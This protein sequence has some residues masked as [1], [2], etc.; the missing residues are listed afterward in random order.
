MTIKKKL[1]IAIPIYN[2]EIRLKEF[3]EDLIFLN[4][5]HIV[6]IIISDDASDD[7]SNQICEKFVK[8][9]DFIKLYTHKENFGMPV[10]NFQFLISKCK[11]EYFMFASPGDPISKTFIHDA[12]IILES[13]ISCGLV[14]GGYQIKDRLSDKKIEIIPNSST[15]TSPVTRY[16]SRVIDMQPALIYGIFRY[17]YLNKIKLDYYDFFEVSLSLKLSI[18]AKI[19][20]LNY[21]VWSWGIEGKRKSYS[22]Y[23]FKKWLS[24]KFFKIKINLQENDLNKG[25]RFSSTQYEKYR[26][27]YLPF[28][29]DQVRTI[30]KN[31]SLFKSLLISI[32]ITY[33]VI[34]KSIKIFVKPSSSD[35]DFKKIE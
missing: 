8:E 11:T 17:K 16:I 23:P 4:I 33:Y 21:N 13:D 24:E 22:I 3:I 5:S 9:Y 19:K 31:F 18:Y 12:L 7:K 26:M 30:F 28:Y 14:F 6:E 1:T 27:F 32:L 25:K 20:I 15:S 2:E 10:K 34:A 35:L 29:L